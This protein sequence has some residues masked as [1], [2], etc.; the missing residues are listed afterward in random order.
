MRTL[1]VIN[2]YAKNHAQ[3]SQAERI[4]EELK[5][6]GVF[7]TVAKNFSLARIERGEIVAKK[8]DFCV[9]L[10]KD[11]VAARM[12]SE[13]CRLYNTPAA[14][15]LCDDKMLTNIALAR[16]GFPLPD[17]IYAPLCYSA[18]A[19]ADKNFLGGV[20]EKLGF[21]LVAKINY[22]SLGAGVSLIKDV[23]A[24]CAYEA[25]N[26]LKPHFYQ[27]YVGKGYGEDIRVIV[28]GGRY[29]CAMRRENKSDFRSNIGLGGKGYRHAADENLISLC[30]NIAKKL[31][32]DYCG[33]DVLRDDFGRYF[34]CEVNS[35]AFFEEA[36]RVCDTNI[37]KIYAKYMVDD[38][39]RSGQTKNL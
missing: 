18:E 29:V 4:A 19:P 3:L 33:I 38:Q 16:F 39:S 20:A 37:A 35:N 25:E 31:G 13:G 22:G 32:L 1:I 14:I 21:P 28:V 34:I 12:L 36:E 9:F 30:E 6:L 23:G 15:E 17:C 5:S 11:R 10:D 8:Y 2:A 7:V 24:L 27:R 26:K